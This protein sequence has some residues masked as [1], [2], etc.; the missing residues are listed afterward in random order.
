MEMDIE[1]KQLSVPIMAHLELTNQ[2]NHRCIHCYRLDSNIV[3]RPRGIIDEDLIVSIAKKLID[4]GILQIVVTGGEPLLNK[5]LV[6]KIVVLANENNVTASI[7]TNLTLADEEIL[8][9][10]Q[11][12]QTRILVSC[13][14][15]IEESYSAITLTDNF[16]IFEKN[17]SAVINMGVKTA[18]NM[19][20]M[21]N[22]IADIQETAKRI[23]KLGCTAFCVTPVALNMDYPQRRLLLSKKDIEQIVNDIMWIESELKMKVDILDGLPKCVFPSK[24]LSEEHLFLYRRCQ[25]GRSFVAVSP[26]GEVRPCANSS[27]SYGNL[28]TENLHEIWAKMSLWRSEDIIPIECKGCTWINRCLGGCRTNAKALTGRWNG[29]DIWTPEPIK[30][31]PPN[32]AKKIQLRSETVLRVADGIQVRKE[33]DGVYL[34]YC[35]KNRTFCMINQSILDF[36][37]LIRES[38]EMSYGQICT[39]YISNANPKL[40]E[41]II[42][43]LIQYKIFKI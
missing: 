12:T 9:F 35:T 22:N 32:H 14:S 5:D 38:K 19:V 4:E 34:M 42:T 26:N 20:V 6:K 3:N 23:H 2:C 1:I 40:V 41:E 31:A 10:I 15:A 43:K 36:V 30:T 28:V 8:E 39:D 29:T 21:K 17:L 24:I 27:I 33:Y 25:A 11:K 16:Q 18:V 7:N 37:N 13:P